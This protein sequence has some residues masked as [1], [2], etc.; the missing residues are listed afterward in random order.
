LLVTL[1]RAGKGE[2]GQVRLSPRMW[3]GKAPSPGHKRDTRTSSFFQR[4]EMARVF[5]LTRPPAQAL[6]RRHT[7][8]YRFARR[9]G[10][11]LVRHPCLIN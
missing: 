2:P 5:A 11:G 7:R 1:T 10:A 6:S 9:G 3:T 8:A 4:T